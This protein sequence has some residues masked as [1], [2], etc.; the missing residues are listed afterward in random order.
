MADDPAQTTRRG[1]KRGGRAR[2]F[3]I[4]PYTAEAKPLGKG[5][6]AAVYRATGPD[7]ATIAIK[8]LFPHLRSDRKMAQ[9][10]RQEYEVV[11][12]L[13]HPNIIRF[14]DFLAANGTH[15]IVME[16]VDGAPLR[17]VLRKA[18]RL[19]AP[20]VAALGY[21][22]VQAVVHI[23]Q[24]GVLHRDLKPSN[25]LIAQDGR[26]KLTDFGIAHQAG[27]R[28]TATGVV[29]GS[30]TYMAPEQLAGKRD[31]VDE[32]TD[33]YALGVVLYECLEGRDP[34]RIRA[35]EDLLAVLHRKLE[36]EPPPPRYADD[37]EFAETLLACL[38]PDPADRLPSATELATRLARIAERAEGAPSGRQLGRRLLEKLGDEKAPP[39]PARRTRQTARTVLDRIGET[40]ALRR[41]RRAFIWLSLAAAAALAIAAFV[42]AGRS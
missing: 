41:E 9:R 28:M 6:M 23:H 39:G 33:V 25:I 11:S 20:L 31:Q 17:Q 36:T 10:F 1:R 40:L 13:D 32:R 14:L 8:E 7:G 38:R 16:Y 18:R 12:R 19:E 24:A 4:G 3:T 22:L 15:N 29:L 26:L 21:Q 34:F 37:P 30:P 5:G 42:L 35:R 2:T 27:T